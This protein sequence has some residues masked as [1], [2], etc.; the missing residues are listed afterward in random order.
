MLMRLEYS[1]TIFVITFIGLW[2]CVL[3]APFDGLRNATYLLGI[4]FTHVVIAISI[5]QNKEQHEKLLKKIEG[6]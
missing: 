5:A 6:S 1:K 3:T 2:L 4:G